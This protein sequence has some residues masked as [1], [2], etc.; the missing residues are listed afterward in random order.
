M[1]FRDH[2]L[3]RSKRLRAYDS[4]PP[5]LGLGSLQKE[6]RV[7]VAVWSKDHSARFATYRETK[8]GRLVDH[9]IIVG[10]PAAVAFL[11][12]EDHG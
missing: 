8:D 3:S 9:A 10:I 12:G 2:P 7:A 4:G 11:E 6:G 5:G 1:N